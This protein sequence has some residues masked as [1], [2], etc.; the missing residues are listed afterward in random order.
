MFHQSK[1]TDIWGELNPKTR[2]F[3]HFS[4]P[5]QSYS[6]IDH[7]MISAHH[8]PLALTSSI[9]EVSW[10]DHSMVMLSLQCDSNSQRVS[11]GT[12]NQSIL[13]DPI[14]VSE[15]TQALKDYLDD[16]D[17]AGEVSPETLWASHKVTIRG[18]LI[19][20]SAR[21]KK[22]RNLEVGRLER[23]FTDL[24]KQHKKDPFSVPISE[25]DAARVALNLALTVKADKSVRWSGAKFYQIRDKI[26]PMLAH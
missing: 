16:D 20:I 4:N 8:I 12:L 17:D 5:H 2:D 6:R 21:Q 11:R 26:G 24:R 22:M 15:I 9:I 1:L 25:L 19:Q 18:K 7:V 3:T 10:S 23:E 13:K 14:V